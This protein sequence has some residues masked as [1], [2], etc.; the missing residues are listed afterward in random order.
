VGPGR[1]E[2]RDHEYERGGMANVLMAFEPLAGRRE[3]EVTE[4]RRGKEF[5]EMVRRLAE[6]V[7]PEAEKVRLWFAT[8]FPPTRPRPSTTPSPP[9][10]RGAWL[11]GCSS[12][13]RRFTARG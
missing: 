10:E 6:E 4:R 2:R 1:P 3:I 7:Y 8:T 5:A 11:G 12:S 13:T 9:S